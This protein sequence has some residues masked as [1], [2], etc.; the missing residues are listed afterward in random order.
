MSQLQEK[1]R[2]TT[3]HGLVLMTGLL[4]VII[5]SATGVTIINPSARA[6]SSEL[7]SDQTVLPDK[8]LPKCP[9]EM[10]D[11]EPLN[12]GKVYF[13]SVPAV[14]GGC[15]LDS[16]RPASRA[17]S[18]RIFEYINFGQF[19]TLTTTALISPKKACEFTLIG[20]KPSGTS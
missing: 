9:G 6:V 2:D 8:T 3:I 11:G 13:L 20:A 7:N 17:V 18:G 5:L 19:K 15:S 14:V 1:D 16:N 4:I 12:S 10:A